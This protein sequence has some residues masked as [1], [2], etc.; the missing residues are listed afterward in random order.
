MPEATLME[1]IDQAI[2]EL[3]WFASRKTNLAT[4]VDRGPADHRLWAD[5]LREDIK[6]LREL[7]EKVQQRDAVVLSAL[8]NSERLFKEA[9]PKF[10]WGASFLDANAIQL[11]NIVPGQ[12]GGAMKVMKEGA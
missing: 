7:I 2:G 8:Q 10:N 9:L 3:E 6:H 4:Q 1:E 5:V 12:V 11:L